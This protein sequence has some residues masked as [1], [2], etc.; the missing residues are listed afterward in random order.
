MSN[1]L[2]TK[3]SD[4]AKVWSMT[5]SADQRQLTVRIPADTFYKVQAL[6]AMFPHRSRNEL[7]ADLLATSLDEFEESLPFETRETSDVIGFDDKNDPIFD[8]Y[9]TGPRADFR[10]FVYQART[11]GSKGVELK[12]VDAEENAA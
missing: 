10:S 3:P 4:L 6:E 9:D 11:N 12:A 2:R 1:Q 5:K 8:S 7:I